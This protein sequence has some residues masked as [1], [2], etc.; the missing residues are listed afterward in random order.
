MHSM[1]V[2]AGILEQDGADLHQKVANRALQLLLYIY[3]FTYSSLPYSLGKQKAV[4]SLTQIL[5]E[6]PYAGIFSRFV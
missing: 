4:L 1:C 2:A 6:F 5:P 3:I